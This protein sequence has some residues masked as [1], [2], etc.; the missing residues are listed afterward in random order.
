MKSVENKYKD[1]FHVIDDNRR[2]FESLLG[3]INDSDN[4][5]ARLCA[6]QKALT[7]AVYRPTGY[8]YS[9]VLEDFYVDLA[10][11]NK[12]SLEN[13]SYVHKSFLHVMTECY[14]TGGHTRVVERWIEHAQSDEKHSVVLLD[15]RDTELPRL[16]KNNIKK[17]NGELF[18]LNKDKSQISRALDLRKLGMGYEY[19]I[20]HIHMDDPISTIAFGSKDFT[21]PVIFFNHAQHLFWIGKRISDIV[22]DFMVGCNI[23]KERRLLTNVYKLPIPIDV[24]K[25]RKLNKLK[26]RNELNISIDK[27]IIITVGSAYK[28]KPILNDYV[29][30]E[31]IDKVL[32][33]NPKACL[34]VMGPDNNDKNWRDL[35]SKFKEKII[36]LGNVSYEKGYLEYLNASDVLIDSY[37]VGGG[38]VCVDAIENECPFVSLK[39]ILGNVDFIAESEGFCKDKEEMILK[40]N[41][42]LNNN[43]YA[44]SVLK[45]E[46]ALFVKDYTNENWNLY[47]N[48]IL[49][50]SESHNIKSL[51]HE[52]EPVLID[53]YCVGLN[54]F[55]KNQVADFI[56]FDEFGICIQIKGF[57]FIFEKRTYECDEGILKILIFFGWKIRYKFIRN[58]RFI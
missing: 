46:K 43:V 52:T 24:A 15:Q 6:A 49:C 3:F 56:S 8:F 10:E 1:F 27:K 5:M 53:D 22:A 7:F 14:S 25:N 19:I 48:N 39:N 17:R 47:L 44:N 36:L 13:I 41:K 58:S 2:K 34:Y 33:T 50:N 20:L 51:D 54:E 23:S 45:N 4:K 21:R 35:K 55:Y 28:Y 29:F 38:T 9:K 16:L 12:L 26:V 32:E 57:P 37:P 11:K 18:V 40:I 30:F 42:I 31:I